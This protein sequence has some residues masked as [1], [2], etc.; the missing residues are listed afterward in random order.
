MQDAFA[1]YLVNAAWQIPVVALCALLVSR[2]AGLSPRAR[3]R[4]W[5]GFLA[6][7]AI[8]PAVSLTAI[9]PHAVP[10]VARVAPEAPAVIAAPMAVASP[11]AEPMLRLAPWSSIAM[12]ALFAL[13]ATALLARLLVASSAARRL[14]RDSRPVILPLEAAKALEGLARAHNRTAPPVRTSSAVHSPAVVGALRPVILIPDGFAAA[15]DDLR[16]AL[17]HELAHVLRHDYAV[18]LACEVLTLPVCWHPALM[19]IKAGVRRSRELACDAIAAQAMSSQ[20][21]YAKC[22]VSLARSL[23][24]PSTPT[25]AALAVGLFGRNDLEDRLM[26]LMKPRDAEGRMIRAARLCGLAAV[27]ASLVGSAALLHVTPVFAQPAPTPVIAP[28]AVAALSEPVAPVAPVPPVAPVARVAPTAPTA[29][30]APVP[31]TP[32]VARHHSGWV[33]SKNGVL[34][35][36]GQTGYHRHTFTGSKGQTITVVTKDPAEPSIAQ[37]RQWEA[38]A[39]DAEAKAAAAEA[40]VNSPEFKAKI[41]KAKADA[42]A[43]RAMVNSPE[44]KAKIAKA[45]ADAEAARAIA[46]SPELKAQIAKARADAET[47]RAMAHS[48]EFTA[49]IAKARADAEAARAVANSPEFKAQIVKA[50][51][52]AETARAMV[53]SP[54]FRAHLARMREEGVQMRREYEDLGAPDHATVNPTP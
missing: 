21:T 44:F 22:L 15:G 14:V 52:E 6:V 18:N 11:A 50:R 46:N 20:K 5:L 26:Q 37:Q 43:A 47:A 1:S 32:P 28:T 39:R 54:E 38:D 41:A 35:E 45:R 40:M 12:V 48:A 10:T 34:I 33:F 53:N 42:E 24:T 13:V 2:F 16:A 23:S 36:V 19:G 31:P 7:A 51:A 49:K 30:V 17:L 9:L 25:N 27:G 4:L 29:P 8:L 3:N